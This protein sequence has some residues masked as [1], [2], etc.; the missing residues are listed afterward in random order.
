MG[1]FNGSF[2]SIGGYVTT[3]VCFHVWIK[4][5][6]GSC[7]ASPWYSTAE[8]SDPAASTSTMFKSKPPSSLAAA[9][10]Q[11][12]MAECVCSLGFTCEI[13]PVPVPGAPGGPQSGPHGTRRRLSASDFE[14]G[15]YESAL[16][17]LKVLYVRII[18]SSVGWDNNNQK[19]MLVLTMIKPWTHF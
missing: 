9:G 11:L 6:F 14:V 8:P 10:E 16:C 7:C 4:E 1:S 17:E 18:V 3:H 5:D 15:L 12:C 2:G 19:L 13:H